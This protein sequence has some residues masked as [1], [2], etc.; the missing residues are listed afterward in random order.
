MQDLDL[1]PWLIQKV[2]SYS[3]NMHRVTEISHKIDYYHNSLIVSSVDVWLNIYREW[4][5]S[6][7]GRYEN[8]T[9]TG[10]L[11]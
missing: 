4:I 8:D 2:L 10:L 7:N 3:Q 11:T 1:L 6:S 5:K 9:A